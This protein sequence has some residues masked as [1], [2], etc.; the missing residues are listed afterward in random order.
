MAPLSHKI[1]RVLIVEDDYD[2][3]LITRDLFNDIAQPKYEVELA[4]SFEKGLNIIA[5]CRHEIYLVDYRLGLK[6]GI[7]L[8]EQAQQLNSKS[9]YILLTG[10]SDYLV[11]VA[12]MQAG[13]SDYLV[14]G[15]ITPQLLD[16]S[17]RYSIESNNYTLLEK[18]K[19]EFISIATH[20]LKTPFTS[21]KAY[22]QLLERKAQHISP[23]QLTE[24]IQKINAQTQRLEDLLT[25]LLD[26]TRL[27]KKNAHFKKSL[28]SLNDVV[29][30]AVQEVQ[31]ITDTHQIQ[32]ESESIPDFLFDAERVQQVVTNL[33]TNAI[34]YSPN[35]N[36]VVVH[37]AQKNKVVEVSVRDFGMGISK[38]DQQ[39]LFER[40]FR[41]KVVLAQNIPGIGLGLYI[42][43]EIVKHHGGKM[44]VESSE[45]QG[46]TFC[47]TLPLEAAV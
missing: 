33:L 3:Y 32:I 17:I 4:D 2:E 20:E 27:N 24:F 7:Q 37:V 12:A 38:E 47:F 21:L 13:A 23:Q 43:H 46:A 10:Q 35:A 44:W 26:V 40:F 39:H 42:S 29:Q 41:T 31:M 34:K 22:V 36:K 15:E 9:P 18:K 1:I 16:R 19:D 45:N 5:E 6:D 8:I 30:K 11:D 14:K 28:S 25:Y